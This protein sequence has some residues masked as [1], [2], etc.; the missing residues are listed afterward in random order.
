MTRIAEA[1]PEGIGEI[2]F[3]KLGQELAVKIDSGI[4][5]SKALGEIRSSPSL[6]AV[7][8]QEINNNVVAPELR[9]LVEAA[10]F[11][12]QEGKDRFNTIIRYGKII[13]DY[14]PRVYTTDAEGLIDTYIENMDGTR[15]DECIG[16]L[17]RVRGKRI[18]HEAKL[19]AEA[20]AGK[21]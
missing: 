18:R 14:V 15:L 12:V 3:A 19:A 13:S 2:D 4:S 6:I 11:T 1:K 21:A 7:P 10:K 20:R 9:I 17:V 5:V 16:D 8:L